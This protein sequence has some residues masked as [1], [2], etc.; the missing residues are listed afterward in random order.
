MWVEIN[1]DIANIYVCEYMCICIVYLCSPKG[2]GSSSAPIRKRKTWFLSTQ[3]LVAKYHSPL[4]RIGL[5]GEIGLMTG[6]GQ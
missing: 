3:S 4:K 6:W 2:L 1:L 5:F